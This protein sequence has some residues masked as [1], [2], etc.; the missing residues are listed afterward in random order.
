MK[1]KLAFKIISVVISLVLIATIITI[2]GTSVIFGAAEKNPVIFVHG[3]G[4]AAFNFSSLQSQ[5]QDNGW[6]KDKMEALNLPS[7]TGSQATNAKAIS[8]AVDKMLEST[9]AEQVDI[10]AHS[11]GGANSLYYIINHEAGDKVNN[12]VTLGGANRLTTSKV[13]EGI[14][15]TNIMGSSDMIVNSSLS[16]ISGSVDVTVNGVTHIGLLTNSKVKDEILKALQEEGSSDDSTSDESSS[17][18]WDKFKNYWESL[19]N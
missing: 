10:I 5:L 17:S 19:R 12:L 14:T 15:L 11:M 16:K 6:E 9:G 13:P 8:E 4:G 3:L 18:R 2:L 1:K 7:K